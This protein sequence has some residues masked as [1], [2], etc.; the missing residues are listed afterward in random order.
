MFIAN[1][2]SMRRMKIYYQFPQLSP[3]ERF[4]CEHL[5]LEE[6]ENQVWYAIVRYEQLDWDYLIC[7]Q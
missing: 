1:V 2:L 3:V 7:I 4:Y 6:I 5:L